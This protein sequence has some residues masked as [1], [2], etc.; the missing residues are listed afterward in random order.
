MAFFGPPPPFVG[1][2]TT[3]AGVSGI[4]P[5]PTSGRSSRILASDATFKNPLQYPNYKNTSNVISNLVFSWQTNPGVSSSPVANERR[6]SL[7]YIPADGEIGS[8]V[9]RVSAGPTTAYNVNVSLWD[10]GEDG[11]PSTYIIGANGSTGTTANVD[12]VTSVT[13][14]S[15]KAGMYYISLT[16]ETTGT[17]GS[18]LGYPGGGT[19][20]QRLY[21]GCANLNASGQIF[22]YTC[23]ASYS[24]QTHETFV[25]S[26]LVIFICGIKYN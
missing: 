25:V 24:Q 17:A 26:G 3:D 14:T 13:P 5:A 16:P 18:I 7:I 2:T 23:S 20:V 15:I 4:V 22:S 19:A 11:A 12:I 10:I 1:A 21:I 6:F 8:L 9:Y